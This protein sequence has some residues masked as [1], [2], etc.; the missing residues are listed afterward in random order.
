MSPDVETPPEAP[1][2]LDSPTPPREAGPPLVRRLEFALVLAVLAWVLVR[3]WN[4][5]QLAW[6][7]TADD[8]YITLRYARHLAEGQGLLW[9]PGEPP[10]EGYSNFTFL[11]LATGALKGGWDP[12]IT[13]KVAG[14]VSSVVALGLSFLLARLFVRGLPA[15][16]APALLSAHP[17]VPWWA[18]S[19]LETLTYM[20]L[21]LGAT[22]AL[23]LGLGH[24]FV[25]DGDAAPRNTRRAYRGS[26]LGAAGLLAALAAMTRPEGPAVFLC[27]AGVFTVDAWGRWRAGE[28]DLRTRTKRAALALALPFVVL[29]GGYFVMR[30]A[31]YGRLWPNTVYCKGSSEAHAPFRQHFKYWD[32]ASTVL[33][34]AL[35]VPVKKLD[36]RYVMLWGF[37]ALY[38]VLLI[39]VDPIVT[40]FDRLFIVPHAFVCVAGAVAAGHMLVFLFD[41]RAPQLRGLLIVALV[42]GY[43]GRLLRIAA[44]PIVSRIEYY[45][46]RMRNRE[47][48]G[49]WLATRM[50]PDQHFVIGDAGVVPYL[51][52]AKVLDAYCLNAGPMTRPPIDRDTEAWADYI[53]EHKPARIV[54]HSSSPTTL[55]PRPEYDMFPVIVDDPRFEL[56]Y[57]Q[58]KVF[59]DSKYSYFVF[60]RKPEA[61]IEAAFE[62]LEAEAQAEAEK[63]RKAAERRAKIEAN[64]RK[65]EATKAAAKTEK[66][67][68]DAAKRA[69]VEVKAKDSAQAGKKD[70]KARAMPTTRGAAKPNPE[71]RA[72]P[73][74]Q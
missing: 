29:F 58:E 4:L 59:P 72:Q 22:L 2:S 26:W 21:A 27:M 14:A 5:V 10:V 30:L 62:K 6:P 57:E 34:M 24:R 38:G 63:A 67:A 31:Y 65:R 56:G 74:P 35:F 60:Q 1:V 11:V 18:V 69:A 55:K 23:F 12:V 32:T 20:G 73:Q 36:A 68:E 64:K 61:E 19:G 42:L 16:L 3:H 28:S 47:D 39:G 40:Y 50:Q 54:V 46:D 37:P 48:L 8:A 33:L 53:L 13:L 49:S 15:C 45:P 41:A 70:P 25:R 7:F 9:N 52:R 51:V 44:K 71:G 17:G 66:K 43:Q